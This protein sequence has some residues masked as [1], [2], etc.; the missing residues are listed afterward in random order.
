MNTVANLKNSIYGI[1]VGLRFNQTFAIG[2]NLG[3]IADKIL[4][5]KNSHF[6]PKLFPFVDSNINQLILRDEDMFNSLIISPTDIILQVRKK[7]D[8]E[9]NI[10]LYEEEYKKQILE[11]ILKLYQVRDVRRVGYLSKYEISDKEIAESFCKRVGI[12]AKNITIRFQK[13][14]TMPETM[15]KKEVNDYCTNIY[16]LVKPP[17]SDK[18]RISSDYQIYFSPYLEDTEDIL[19]DEFI[20][21]K[22]NFNE[23]TLPDWING[24]LTK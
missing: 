9:L 16:T 20:K 12:D 5:S 14:Y 3:K 17:D 19:Y 18:L 8:G 7:V 11:S 21:E 13:N 1:A 2:D 15:Q 24:Y 10:K 22:N 4:Y 23:K 6:D